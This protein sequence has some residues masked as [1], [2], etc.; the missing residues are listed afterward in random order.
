MS[1][2]T[3]FDIKFNIRNSSEEQRIQEKKIILD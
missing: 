3:A 1:S 2:F